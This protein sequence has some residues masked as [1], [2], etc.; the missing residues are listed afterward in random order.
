M[1]DNTNTHTF[2]R[3]D[4]LKTT[5]TASAASLVI[6]P[7][8]L[9][10]RS[11][12]AA[13]GTRTLT[14]GRSIG[15]ATF[16]PIL[17]AANRD[18]WVL[19]NM[20]ANLVRVTYDGDGIEPDLAESWDISDDGKR[21][22]FKLRDGLKFS[23]GSSL[24]PSDVK[25]SLERVR[26]DEGSVLST[27]FQ[28]IKEVNTPDEQQVEIV[29]SEPSAPLLSTLAMFSASIV[30][31]AVVKEKG[32]QFASQPVGAGAFK[33]E[34]WDQ[35][36]NVTLVKND[37][38]WQSDKVEVDRVVWEYISNDNTRILNL[39]SAQINAAISI[40]FNKI[41]PLSD[42]DEIDIHVDKSSR[43]DMLIINHKHKPLDDVR[44]RKALFHGINREALIE[45]ALHGY[46]EVSNSFIPDGGMFYNPDNPTY[47]FNQD[48]ARALL[49]DAGVEDLELTLMIS[50]GN[51]IGNQVAVMIQA[52]LKKIGV[53]INIAKHESGELWNTLHTGEFDLSMNYWVNDIIDPDQKASFS[54]YGY[55]DSRSYFTNYKSSKMKE[56]IEEGRKITDRKEREK[57]YDQI[58]RLAVE[59][60]VYINLYYRPFVNA[61]RD[62]VD[63]FY[64]N[65][66]GRF[67]LE[68][69]SVQS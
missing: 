7:G 17:T 53:K 44:V 26:D 65:P 42:D 45:I 55:N 69:T 18:I 32:D 4:F 49:E 34:Q 41:K 63:R 3:R 1:K 25:F 9:W 46:G 37:H 36:S 57:V 27:M 2:T 50:T 12:Q 47:E 21:Y 43:E 19:D 31:E 13:D 60:V 68:G 14:I 30:P 28:S 38:Y 23:D 5:G 52:M 11:S 35:Q 61:S 66:T 54:L 51:Q 33:L 48:K 22:L 58:Q 10:T 39:Q 16:D 15:T 67:M 20:N 59:D 6:G 29:L 64:Q 62:D 56:L 24:E 8:V 40:P